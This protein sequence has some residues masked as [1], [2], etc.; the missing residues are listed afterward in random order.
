MRPSVL[1]VH[2]HCE[3]AGTG[4]RTDGHGRNSFVINI[5]RGSGNWHGTIFCAFDQPRIQRFL[6]LQD[7]PYVGFRFAFVP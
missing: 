5:A 3:S 2:W 1:S 7:M 6:D 4:R